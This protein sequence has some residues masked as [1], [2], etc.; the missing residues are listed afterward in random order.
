MQFPPY[1]TRGLTALVVGYA[2]GIAPQ[3][4]RIFHLDWILILNVTHVAFFLK[5][6]GLTL[7]TP[8]PLLLAS[9]RALQA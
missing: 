1:R 2:R 7:W 3:P 9:L 4:K 5:A 6:Q 8:I